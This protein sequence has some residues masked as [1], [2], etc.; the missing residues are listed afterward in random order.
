[1]PLGHT[2]SSRTQGIFPSTKGNS[3]V[4][5]QKCAIL[6]EIQWVI[7]NIKVAPGA[8]VVHNPQG[9]G[10]FPGLTGATFSPSPYLFQAFFSSQII[11]FEFTFKSKININKNLVVNVKFNLQLEQL[12]SKVHCC[13]HGL[14]PNFWFRVEN[15]GREHPLDTV[16]RV[17][18]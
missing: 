18:M 4:I 14:R 13:F 17:T 10:T 12:E 15:N 6:L 11:F 9:P 8:L 5:L 3:R 16:H 1:M 7:S 2:Y